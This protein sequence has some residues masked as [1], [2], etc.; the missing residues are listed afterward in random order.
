[1]APGDRAVGE[2]VHELGAVRQGGAVLEGPEQRARGGAGAP[3]EDARAGVD[4]LHGPLRG[5][6]AL[7]PAVDHRRS[8]ISSSRAD[9]ESISLPPL[10][11]Q[12]SGVR[13][14]VRLRVGPLGAAGAPTHAFNRSCACDTHLP[15]RVCPPPDC[16]PGGAGPGVTANPR[17]AS[18]HRGRDASRWHG[19]CSR[20]A[21]EPML[22]LPRGLTRATA[23]D[24]NPWDIIID[25]S[26]TLSVSE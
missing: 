20:S 17:D 26:G 1:R 21:R 6:R 3:D 15:R 14:S 25:L 4:A 8:P 9:A 24:A 2:E 12:R 18:L 19:R 11:G 5:D 23:T 10:E 7:V 13:R 22:P 16:E